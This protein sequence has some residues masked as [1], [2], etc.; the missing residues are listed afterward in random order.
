ML[1][2]SII[3]MLVPSSS[4]QSISTE[5]M[6]SHC[7]EKE[8]L[9]CPT[10]DLSMRE[11]LL[12]AS[13]GKLELSKYVYYILVWTLTLEGELVPLNIDEIKAT[14]ATVDITERDNGRS[15]KIKLLDSSKAHKTLETYR[16]ITSNQDTQIQIL[17]E[18]SDWLARIATGSQLRRRQSITAYN[19]IYMSSTTYSLATSFF[20]VTELKKIQMNAV[21]SFL[22]IIGFNQPT[23]RSIVFGPLEHGGIGPQ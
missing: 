21:R 20:T 18:K 7:A 16:K 12:S 13:G 3:V 9:P 14:G 8:L 15:L 11:Q 1:P 10:A 5:L 6:L 4:K 2:G 23:H 19:M 17:Q 22:P